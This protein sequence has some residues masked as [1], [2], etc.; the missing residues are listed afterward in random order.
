MI[1]SPQSTPLQ[2]I[3]PGK[4]VAS[5]TEIQYYMLANLMN[6]IYRQLEFAR[7]RATLTELFFP[8]VLSSS[9]TFINMDWASHNETTLLIME[10]K[11]VIHC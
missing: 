11:S 2:Q 5:Q 8:S 6:V 7:A 1:V 3:L 10:S 9:I 4:A